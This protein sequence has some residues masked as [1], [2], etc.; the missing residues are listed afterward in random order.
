MRFVLNQSNLG[1]VCCEEC[2]SVPLCAAA[3]SAADA[4]H[5]ILNTVAA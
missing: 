2:V 3:G 5:V 4:M 1:V